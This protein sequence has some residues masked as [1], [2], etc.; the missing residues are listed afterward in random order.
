MNVEQLIRS[1][2]ER[3]DA[4]Q[5][6]YGH[7]TDNALDEAAWLVFAALQLDHD[8]AASAYTEAVA[9]EQLAVVMALA[10]RRIQERVPLA[11]LINRAWFAGHEFYVDERVLVPRSPLSEWILKQ[12]SPWIA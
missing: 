11:Y 6:H 10:E 12:F 3:F 1:L 8:E 7:G 2:S 9:E 4:A 5:L